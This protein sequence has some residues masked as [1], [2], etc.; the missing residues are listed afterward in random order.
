MDP[1]TPSCPASDGWLTGGICKHF[2]ISGCPS[3]QTLGVIINYVQPGMTSR[4]TIVF[5]SGG[6]G[7]TP[8]T[9]TGQELSFA[10]DYLAARFA[11]VQTR[12]DSDWE[13]TN[14]PSDGG[15]PYAPNILLAACR[16]AT[17]L[18]KINSSSTFHPAGAMCAQG[19]SAGSAAVAYSLVWY[20]A[21]TFY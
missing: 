11:M 17:L 3:A 19:G 15:L 14:S 2:T 1:G 5:F 9:D 16:P 18:S 13:S 20:G 8:T 7:T 4:G 6:G 12:W 10:A 21:K